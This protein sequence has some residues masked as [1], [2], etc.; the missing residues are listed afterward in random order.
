MNI[1][2]NLSW[3]FKPGHLLQTIKYLTDQSDMK[4]ILFLILLFVYVHSSG[5]IITTVAGNGTYGYSGNGG[6]A[7]SA[8]LAWQMGVVADNSGNIYFNIWI[9]SNNLHI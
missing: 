9:S 3:S 7:T 4:R 6:I 5:Q 2:S 1:V 8:Q